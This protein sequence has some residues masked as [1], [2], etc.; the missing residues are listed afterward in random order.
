MDLGIFTNKHGSTENKPGSAAYLVAGIPVYQLTCFYSKFTLMSQNL[1]SF[2][3]AWW[4]D[5]AWTS[6]IKN[7]MRFIKYN[8]PQLICHF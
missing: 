7:M 6:S 5:Q 4:A 1:Q 8:E 2:V 3:Q